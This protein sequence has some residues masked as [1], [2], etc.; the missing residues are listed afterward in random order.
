MFLGYK[1]SK[2][3]STLVHTPLLQ[4]S[5]DLKDKPTCRQTR[6]K[7]STITLNAYNITLH[8]KYHNQQRDGIEV[9][10]TTT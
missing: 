10:A 1:L 7:R 8:V 2:L 9:G 5:K 3:C 4:N 6:K